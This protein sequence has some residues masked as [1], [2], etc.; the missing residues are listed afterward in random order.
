MERYQDK[1]FALIGVNLDPDRDQAQ[2][3]CLAN[4]LNWRSFSDGA[5]AIQA[6]YGIPCIPS[7]CLI[8]ANGVLRYKLDMASIAQLDSLID[9]LL[10]EATAPK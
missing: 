5:G 9:N 6:R 7:L 8:D 1:P 10:R 4:K 3:A 2:R